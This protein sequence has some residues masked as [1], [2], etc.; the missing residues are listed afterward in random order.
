MHK[1]QSSHHR[2][3]L[4]VLLD[5]PLSYPMVES[6]I[7]TI[8]FITFYGHCMTYV[9]I[10]VRPFPVTSLVSIHSPSLLLVFA[11]NTWFSRQH[12]TPPV[13]LRVDQ[14]IVINSLLYSQVH[15]Y[16]HSMID[17]V[18]TLHNQGMSPLTS[19]TPSTTFYLS[20]QPP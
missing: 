13:T 14:L 19:D 15:P 6:V 8:P 3:R 17:D 5:Y 9:A 4:F 16:H 18:I 11:I 10:E 20:S 12:G 2:P 1:W 7:P